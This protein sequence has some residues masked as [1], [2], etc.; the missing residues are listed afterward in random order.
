MKSSILVS[1]A[2]FLCIGF[3]SG[4]MLLG[5]AGCSLF[6]DPRQDVTI[7][8]SDPSARLFVDGREVGVGKAVVPLKRN[9]TYAVRATLP[10]GRFAGTRIRRNVSTTG[11]I[12]V[13]GG[14]FLLF[15][16]LGVLGPGFWQ[17]EPDYL[18]LRIP[19]EQPGTQP[20]Q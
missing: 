12:D 16:F 3:V 8:A 1:A 14:I 4:V 5:Q 20:G 13:V 19:D 10:D 18:F 9:D 7:E 15:P 17:L 2:R 11:V 6:V